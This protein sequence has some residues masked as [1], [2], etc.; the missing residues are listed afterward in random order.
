MKV[1]NKSVD[2]ITSDVTENDLNLVQQ[3]NAVSS[4]NF[5]GMNPTKDNKNFVNALSPNKLPFMGEINIDQ[6]YTYPNNFKQNVQSFEQYMWFLVNRVTTNMFQYEGLPKEIDLIGYERKLVQNGSVY[7]VKYKDKF[8]AVNGVGIEWDIYDNPTAI[9]I[10]EPRSTANNKIL[11]EGNFV[12]IKANSQRLSINML[13]SW[14]IEKLS[15]TFHRLG[16]E[17]FST[18][19]KFV[20]LG[21]FFDLNDDLQTSAE[22]QEQFLKGSH[23]ISQYVFDLDS[24]SHGTAPIKEQAFV[25][26]TTEDRRGQ[27]NANYEYLFNQLKDCLGITQNGGFS[28]KERTTTDH[29]ESAQGINEIIKT[30]GLLCRTLGWDK[31]NEILGTNVTVV[32]KEKEEQKEA[33]QEQREHE[34]TLSKGSDNNA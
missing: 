11:K 5:K 21:G 2:P 23:M 25:D 20:M 15:A 34:V 18:L 13:Y 17:T 32:D 33:L 12:E 16:I 6:N 9:K 14:I 19:P 7:I 4:V 31:A 29:V 26:L 30:E 22:N 28:E 8:L 10:V 1:I 3:L 27:T 24:A